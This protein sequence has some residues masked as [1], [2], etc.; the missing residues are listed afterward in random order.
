MRKSSDRKN[1][2]VAGLAG[3]M[4]LFSGVA[5]ADECNF[6]SPN[7]FR[8]ATE[9]AI[10]NCI[11]GGSDINIRNVAGWMPLHFAA[12][13]NDDPAIISFLIEKGADI[14]GRNDN[15]RGALHMAA[16]Y[17]TEPAVIHVLVEAGYK[18][19]ERDIGGGTPLHS[20]AAH[21]AEP[22]IVT[23]LL[24]VGADVSSRTGNSGAT[25]LH[26]AARY[27]KTSAVISHL[28]EAGADPELPDKHGR[29]AWDYV[30]ANPSLSFMLES[31]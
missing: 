29:T 2:C 18:I 19:D 8:D 4:F 9:Q 26:L 17:S 6:S 3:S 15:G 30:Q 10:E 27:S 20:A 28:L 1:A 31:M 11:Q 14:D 12:A 25:P 21:N 22:A 13:F 16:T 23:A 7:F 24:S 5:V